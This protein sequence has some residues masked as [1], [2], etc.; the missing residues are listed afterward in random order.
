MNV[1]FAILFHFYTLGIFREVAINA[2]EALEA[3]RELLSSKENGDECAA[4]KSAALYRKHVI[5]A[6]VLLIF[7]PIKL[8]Y[9]IGL[10][11]K[12][13]CFTPSKGDDL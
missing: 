4:A 12:L 7:W 10:E 3:R 9:F 11:V 5:Y 13:M 2:A 6:M 8:L 1:L